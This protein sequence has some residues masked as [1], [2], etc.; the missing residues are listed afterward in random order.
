M[1]YKKEGLLLKVENVSLSY[2]NRPILQNINFEIY[3]IVRPNMTQGQVVSVIGRSGIGKTQ[4]FK[5]LSGLKKPDTGFVK[6]GANLHPV[7]AGDVG[8]IPQNY[9]LFNHRSIKDNLRIALENCGKKLTSKEKDD[10]VADYASRFQLQDELRKYPMQLSGGQRQRVSIIQQILTGN[11]FILLDEPFSGLDIVMKDKVVE[12]LVKL[13]LTHEETTLIIVSH[14]IESSLAISDTA[15]IL[16][17]PDE[18]HG[19]T[20]KEVVDLMDLDLAWHPDIKTNPKFKQ[21]VDEMRNR[22]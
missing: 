11:N 8:V 14:D 1:V 12:L 7:Q 15:F 10:I 6:I 21:L 9:L 5:I 16:A 20:I 13:S 18:N 17:R 4:L 19:A 22:I 3:D 2:D